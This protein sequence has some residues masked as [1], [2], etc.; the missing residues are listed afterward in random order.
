MVPAITNCFKI[1]IVWSFFE[2]Y[3]F[4][5]LNPLFSFSLNLNFHAKIG[6]EVLAFDWLIRKNGVTSI[7]S[8]NMYLCSM[9]IQGVVC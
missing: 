9:F 3:D 7:D 8:S 1:G 6:N 5:N 4:Q 2:D